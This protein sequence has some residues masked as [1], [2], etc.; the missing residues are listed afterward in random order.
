MEAEKAKLTCPQ[1]YYYIVG[2]SGSARTRFTTRFWTLLDK[3]GC[4]P[5]EL[6]SSSRT[7]R[8]PP[9][10]AIMSDKPRVYQGVRVRTTVKE[11]LQR[12]RAREDRGGA[13]KTISQ[14]C[15]DLQGL[16]SSTCPVR[17]V[18]PPPPLPAAAPSCGARAAFQ[19]DSACDPQMQS[20]GF[21]DI[22]QQFGDMML[23]SNGYDGGHNHNNHHNQHHSGYSACLPP[24]PAFPLPG[25]Q[26][27]SSDADYYG[28]GM[29][30]CSSPEL[31]TLCNP[32]N[33]SSDSPQDSFSS[34]SSSSCYDS[35]TR[36]ESGYPAGL[37]CER[38]HHQHCGLQDCWPGPQES[39]SAPE[40][41]PYFPPTDY[42]YACPVEGDYF[43]RD[44]QMSSEMCYNVL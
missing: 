8:S 35:P 33:H 4:W 30:P 31:L 40:Y 26:G 27:L 9:R 21:H 13:A 19:L 39:F 6:S 15:A 37:P 32:A 41:G 11:L 28:P 14:A 2:G 38:F 42:E 5:L 43:R 7:V 22:Q 24:P 17:H 44:S 29:A 23:P 1:L 16:C 18:A 20:S 3:F 10:A 25:F 12:L 34:S 36:M